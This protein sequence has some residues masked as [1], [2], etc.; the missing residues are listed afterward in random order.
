MS[1]ARTN[2]LA[3]CFQEVLTAVLRVRFRRQQVQDAQS[4]RAQMRATLQA[5]MQEARALGYSSETVQ[6]AV[7]A[8]VAYLDESVLTLQSPV[9]ADWP[10]QTM[11]E[12][13]FGVQLAGET[14]FQNMAKLLN[15]QDSSEV[16]DAL[17]L[18]CL[19]LQMGYR[20]RFALGDTGE[21]GQ[22]IRQA[23]A[24]IQ[25]V[26]GAATLMPAVVAPP[27]PPSRTR[28]PWTGALL[29]GTCALA[30][31]TIVAFGAYELLL[32]SGVSS[33]MSSGTILY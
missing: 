18:H 16:A 19:C 28:D 23:L 8:T 27:V 10:R 11:Q 21:L 2:S 12:Q 7:F 1:T 17:E 24:K 22:M 9:F 3:L 6:T 20:G 14:F 33:V 15:E 32:T 29:I 25:R 13:L 31:L 4:F 5:A 26:R 30:V